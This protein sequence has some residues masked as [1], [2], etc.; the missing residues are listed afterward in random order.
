MK[1]IAERRV[2]R[3][4][5]HQ[6]LDALGNDRDQVATSLAAGGVRGV[7]R[8]VQ[9]CAVAVYLAAVIGADPR[10]KAITVN[11]TRLQIRLQS[12]GTP[13]LVLRLPPA[14]REFIVAFDAGRF[15]SLVRTT[16]SSRQTP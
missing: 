15:P 7:P 16:G 9:G 4:Q 14:V 2:I 5:T 11:D 3:Q 10:V 8:R 1:W 6:L 13:P 12:H